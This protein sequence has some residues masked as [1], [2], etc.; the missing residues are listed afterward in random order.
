MANLAAGK[1][2]ITITLPDRVLDRLDE[3][4]RQKGVTKSV[5]ITIMTDQL[6]PETAKPAPAKDKDDVELEQLLKE[7]GYN[8]GEWR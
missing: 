4:A 3:V 6:Y 8:K 5:L 7:V 2:R 1:T